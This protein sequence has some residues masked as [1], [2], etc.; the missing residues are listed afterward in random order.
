M[1]DGE[2][3]FNTDHKGHWKREVYYSQVIRGGTPCALRGHT[4]WWRQGE[5]RGRTWG[6]RLY[7]SLWVECVGLLRLRLNGSIQKS[8]VLVNAMVVLAKGTYG[9]QAL[10]AKG[11]F[12]H[13]GCWGSH[14]RDL[15]LL[16][17]WG[18]SPGH[19]PAWGVSVSLRTLQATWQT[20][21]MLLQYYYGVA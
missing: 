3:K 11:V 15:H 9:T 16:V 13:K 21:W 7:E 14:T 18:C 20:K 5:V 12:D 17:T 1:S 19:A 6:T 4:G 10:G 8:G 2:P